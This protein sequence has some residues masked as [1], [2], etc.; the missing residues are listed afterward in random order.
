MQK[1]ILSP[2]SP[3]EEIQRRQP[4]CRFWFS[5]RGPGAGYREDHGQHQMGDREQSPCAEVVY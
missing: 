1:F 4:P 5:H 2:V 3:A